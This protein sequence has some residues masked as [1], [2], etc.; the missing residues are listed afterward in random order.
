MST[1]DRNRHP[2]NPHRKR[3]GAKRPAMK[4]LDRD[5]LVEA[6]VAQARR[7]TVSKTCPVDRRNVCAT[8]DRQLIQGK[9]RHIATDYH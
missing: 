6:E 8:P 1:P 5:A 9:F 7:V 2:A 4:R 3:I